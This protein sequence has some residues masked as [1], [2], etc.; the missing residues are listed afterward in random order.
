[1]NSKSIVNSLLLCFCLT[2]MFYSCVPLRKQLLVIDKNK[3]TLGKIQLEDTI[4][5]VVPYEYRIRKGDILSVQIINIT[6]GE[7]KLDNVAM[8]GADAES[9]Y[10]VGDLGIIDIPVIGKVKVGGLTIEESRDTLKVIASQ[11]LNNV[12]VNV[13][14]LSFEVRV[15]GELAGVIKSPDGKLNILQ[16]LAQAGWSREYSNLERVKI[17]REIEKDKIHVYYIDV[18][19]IG[20]ISKPEFYLM[21]KDIVAVEP[22]RAKN[23]N[24]TRSLIA[25]GI[26]TV[27]VVFLLYNV[28]N[29]FKK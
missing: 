24:N 15:V 2:L 14:F 13:K 11:F 19:D 10:I 3:K 17:I 21:P 16:A 4:V 12:V 28:V 22:R 7:Y 9:G 20:I 1:M 27:S 23:F 5:S 26:S 8:A 18:S 6:P 25:F 29:L